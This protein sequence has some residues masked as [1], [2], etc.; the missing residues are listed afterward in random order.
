MNKT[1]NNNKINTIIRKLFS[2]RISYQPPYLFIIG[3][4]KGGDKRIGVFF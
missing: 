4:K 1:D 3:I 2:K